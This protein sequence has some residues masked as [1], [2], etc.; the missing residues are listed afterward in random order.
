MIPGREILSLL[1]ACHVTVR[2]FRLEMLSLK[3][4]APALRVIHDCSF[5]IFLP[6]HK[7]Y[8]HLIKLGNVIISNVI[9]SNVTN[10]IRSRTKLSHVLVIVLC[11]RY[12]PEWF[13][14]TAIRTVHVHVEADRPPASAALAARK[15]GA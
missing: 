3:C 8:H 14:D 6:G 15:Y 2:T 7:K 11:T 13:S 9:I 5:S 1:A 4:F 10:V 12:S